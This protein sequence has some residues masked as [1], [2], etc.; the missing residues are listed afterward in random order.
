LAETLRELAAESD[1]LLIVQT[2]G[3]R[4]LRFSYRMRNNKIS[5][6]INLPSQPTSKIIDT[7]GAGDWCTTGLLFS[8]IS[9]SRVCRTWFNKDELIAALQFGQAL[10]AISCSFIGAQGILYA[11]KSHENKSLLRDLRKF[12]K[13]KLNTF[14]LSME[15]T[16]SLCQTCLLPL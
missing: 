1:I 5:N 13:N 14:A 15:K 2:M 7:V 6:W 8:L 10:A 11:D 12:K 3:S 4:G 16:I 9:R